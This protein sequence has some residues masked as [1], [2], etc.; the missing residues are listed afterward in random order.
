MYYILTQRILECVC[1]KCVCLLNPIKPSKGVCTLER[2][3]GSSEQLLAGR[4]KDGLP[5]AGFTAPGSVLGLVVMG[6]KAI[7]SHPR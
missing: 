7:V 5:A 2:N 3:R 6:E 1:V 4:L